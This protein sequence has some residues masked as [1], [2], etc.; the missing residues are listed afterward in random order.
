MDDLIEFLKVKIEV[1]ARAICN[2]SNSQ[3]NDFAASAIEHL[4]RSINY[5][6]QVKERE[7]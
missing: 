3:S 7:N 2:S 6:Y 4:S 5:L 1:C